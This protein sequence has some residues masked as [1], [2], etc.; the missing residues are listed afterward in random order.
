[1]SSISNAATRR[2]RV[3]AMLWTLRSFA[4]LVALA[5]VLALSGAAFEAIASS[6]DAAAPPPAG[7]L[8]D[9]GGFRLHLHCMG[10]GIPTVVLDA[11][12]GRESLDWSLVQPD[13][14]RTTRVCAYDRA[15]MGWS[16]P[17]PHQRTPAAVA[18]ELHALLD[19]AGVSG[20]YVLAAHSLSGKY[21]RMFAVRYPREVAGVVLV[22]ARHEYV[23]AFTTP[24]E[25][26][27]F[28]DAVDAQG[29]T[30]AWARRLGVVRMFGS[31]LAGT[32]AFP[33][34]TRRAMALIA[35]RAAAIT[36]TSAEARQRAANDAEL[37]ASSLGDHPLIVLAAGE[38]MTGI[39]HWSEAQRRQAALSSRGELRV[40]QGSSHC[41]Q[42]D[43]PELVTRA[44]EEIVATV[45]FQ[46]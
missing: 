32:P 33:A 39:P 36:A 23:D 16:D 24:D 43:D 17:S 22:D 28:F 21:A 37:E 1:M 45:R 20:P 4:A 29:E 38:S 27:A 6:R 30:Y 44:I 12:L 18:R 11:G 26:Q 13:V 14:A 10:E 7:R 46:R 31:S 15:G 41:I 19:N 2:K 3:G 8:V 40:A 9:V 35:T 25:N 5:A 34:A 42:C